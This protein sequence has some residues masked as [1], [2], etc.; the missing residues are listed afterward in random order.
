M[1]ERVLLEVHAHTSESSPCAEL[2]AAELVAALHAAGYGAAVI[3]DHYLPGCCA[4]RPARE[5]FLAGYRAAR[6]GRRPPRRPAQGNGH[7][8]WHIPETRTTSPRC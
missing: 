2:T 7:G 8:S 6:S 4:S 3:T 1:S 5:A